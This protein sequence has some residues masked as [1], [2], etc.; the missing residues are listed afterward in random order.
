LRLAVFKFKIC[1]VSGKTNVVADCFTRQYEDL[2]A[3]DTFTG[4]VMQ[5]LPEAF[6]SIQE[7]QKKVPFCK[8]LYPK[9]FR[10]DQLRDPSSYFTF[11]GRSALFGTAMSMVVV[12]KV[13]QIVQSGI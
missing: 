2:S 12:A 6:R 5:H 9:V 1:H 3:E 10:A 8:D 7:H 4:F 13:H 11:S